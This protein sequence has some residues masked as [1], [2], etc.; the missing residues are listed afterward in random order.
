MVLILNAYKDLW[1]ILKF[2]A[3]INLKDKVAISGLV[4]IES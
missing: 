4:L 2:K 3:L 1:P